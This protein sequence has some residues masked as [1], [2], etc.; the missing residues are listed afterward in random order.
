[1]RHKLVVSVADQDVPRLSFIYHK[2]ETNPDFRIWSVERPNEHRYV[3][4]NIYRQ[5]KHS[6]NMEERLQRSIWQ[7]IAFKNSTREN[8]AVHTYYTYWYE[9]SEI[10]FFVV[11]SQ[12][13]L[14]YIRCCM[15]K[16]EKF[17]K[18]NSIQ[19]SSNKNFDV[20]HRPGAK[21]K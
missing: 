13:N 20:A 4:Y 9:I 5:L 10:H 17:L 7:W 14:G 15:R 3:T 19:F 16:S 11:F 6:S 18:L 12:S 21:E 8:N 2:I 1:M